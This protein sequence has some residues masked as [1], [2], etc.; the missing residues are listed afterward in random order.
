MAALISG[1]G[2]VLA[3]FIVKQ[4]NKWLIG[5]PL[6]LFQLVRILIGVHPGLLRFSMVIFGFNSTAIALYMS[7]G[8]HPFVPAMIAL[9][10][11]YNIMVILLMMGKTL[12]N[13]VMDMSPKATWA[14]GPVLTNFC[15]LAVLFLEL[16]CFFYAIAM[17]ISLGQQIMAGEVDYSQGMAIRLQ[18][19]A[20]V[21]VPALFI[22]A[23]C[24]TIAIH[25]MS[26]WSTRH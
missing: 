16:P 9:I 21:I 12:E 4:G 11:G 6:L 22:S 14:P 18:A 15:G 19:Y 8:F 24:E 7:S 17:G 10:T 5:L 20:M 1:S 13:D 3:F 26:R 23:I 25:G 2:S